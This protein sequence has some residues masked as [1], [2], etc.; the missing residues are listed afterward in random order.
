MTAN[1]QVQNTTLSQWKASRKL[2]KLAQAGLKARYGAS[3]RD[4][5][6]R[7]AQPDGGKV[8]QGETRRIRAVLPEVRRCAGG[9]Q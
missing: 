5:T 2:R 1:I 4:M 9:P 6:S 8:H 3:P 7:L